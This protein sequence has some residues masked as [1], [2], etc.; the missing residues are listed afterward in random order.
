MTKIRL[1]GWRRAFQAQET[2]ENKPAQETLSG[3]ATT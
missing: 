3:I 2:I 1:T